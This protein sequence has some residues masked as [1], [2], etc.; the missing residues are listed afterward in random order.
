MKTQKIAK[1]SKIR[2]NF[3]QVAAIFILIGFVS[4]LFFWYT[5]QNLIRMTER[6]KLYAF[7]A[8]QIK[9][10]QIDDDFNNSLDMI[11]TYAHFVGDNLPSPVI[12]LPTLEMLQ[13][14]VFDAMMFADTNGVDVVFDGRSALAENREFFRKGIAGGTGIDVVFSSD[15]YDDSM[16]SFYTPLHYKGRLIG[17][18]RGAYF[19]EKY[20]KRM[21]ETSYF[22]EPS[23]VFL[24][25]SDG[26]IVA[27]SGRK[28][29]GRYLLDSLVKDGVISGETADAVRKMFADGKSGVFTCEV[30]SKMDNISIAPL[31]SN[32]FV[33]VQLFP[34][35]VTNKMIHAE[36]AIGMKIALALILVFIIYIGVLIYS[37]ACARKRLETENR[38][39][40]YIISGMKALFTR[41]AIADLNEGTYT[42][43]SGTKPE[44]SRL[45]NSGVYSELVDYFCDILV[46]PEEK[47][48]LREQISIERIKN[49]LKE[50]SDLRIECH[51]KNGDWN[52]INIIR[53][54][55]GGKVLFARQNTTYTKK[56]E[57]KIQAELEN[58]YRKER[59]YRI[60]IMS[61]SF[62]TFEFNVS[63]DLI[64]SDITRTLEDGTKISFLEKCALSAPCK[65]SECFLAWE[66]FVS[67][68]SLE[69][70]RAT[71]N[72][73]SL[74]QKYEK[75]EKEVSVDYWASAGQ[76]R[77]M[78]V[79]QSFIMTRD[80]KGDII[81]MVISR[82]IT[83]QVKKQ[84]EQ[85][86][87]LQDALL[88]AQHANNAKTTF[89]SNM[90]HDIR[91][92]MNAIIGFTTIA[93]SHIDNKEQVRDCL[94]KVLSSS[95]HL[96]SLIND[97]LDMSRIESG[98]VQIK[99][100]EC[101]ISE[102]M[103]SLVN[104][105][106]PQVKAKQL[107]LFIDTFE[108]VNEDVIADALK[109]NQVFI[110]L[111]SN[112]VK[113]TPAG[114][115]VSFRIMQKT[116]FRHGWGDYTF[117]V[118]DNGIGMSPDFVTH[119]FEPFERESTVT[120]S[121]I[122]GTGLGMAITKN[123]VEMMGGTISVE[124]E[125]G[126]GST[127]TVELSLKLQ[128]V[129]KNAEQ[130][131]ELDGL[132]ALVVDDDL[133][134]CDSVNKMLKQLG[135]RAEW[136]TSG[137]EAAYR[138]KTAH[139][140]GDSYHTYI[141][142]WQMPEMNGV[143]TA[144]RIRAAVGSEA[145]II[146]LTAYDWTDIEEEARSVGVTAFC[147]KPLFLSDLKAALLAANNS[148]SA[149]DEEEKSAS[150][151][152][153]DF[154]G[155]RVLLVDDVEM[156]REI[157]QVILEEAGFAVETAPDGTDAVVMVEKSSENYYDAILMDV[158]MPIMDGYEATRTI[159]DMPRG[160]VKTMPIIAM[161]ANAM[162][163]DKETA[164]KNGMNA[165]I[166]K[167]LDIDIFISVLKKFLGG[168]GVNSNG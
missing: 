45:K 9:A 105:I 65:A 104:I 116:T 51:M 16:L 97:I 167:P 128:D 62:N 38:D 117:I 32:Q 60:A 81:A 25:E 100:Q 157:A 130:L 91:T 149:K 54:D 132:R 21:L 159:R 34:S 14:G 106:Q 99:E 123:I 37:A 27:S 49:S 92:P 108:V 147:A 135:M 166:A 2:K 29:S 144:R 6:N 8:A 59:Q 162:E 82:D 15:F 72:P 20:L 111:L 80:D 142:D 31:P 78:C 44:D 23:D 158:Q 10:D 46:V 88:Q 36:N 113:Y 154:G 41:F 66:K 11:Q 143:E 107:E 70:F 61:N 64:E 98:K 39:M 148:S 43:L 30:K 74:R 89:L 52:H 109:M 139:E 110:N 7:D 56:K 122:Q 96:L 57:L 42:Y 134:V 33:L 133:N 40:G 28:A 118:K 150:W 141:I 145:P 58:T 120:Q 131:K 138:A 83:E 103:H 35:A 77:K 114:G 85:T 22:G 48:S 102:M 165:H 87:A 75:G 163:E 90:S 63:Q 95:N 161:T 47:E 17:V 68:D 67:S 155:K 101:N 151:A 93:A 168:E 50:R 53:I 152:L 115:S 140:E 119:I 112:A 94:Q 19:A 26:R 146:I 153:E 55:G 86:Q 71:V 76:G 160:D 164:L 18:L 156:N 1:F 84:Y 73:E 12:D 137:C 69:D 125:Q 79:R 124:S 129:E 24:C 13:N 121:G 127:F 4:L 3:L 126:K 136:T 5:R